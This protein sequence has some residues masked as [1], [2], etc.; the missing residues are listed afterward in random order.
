MISKF[1]PPKP[2]APEWYFNGVQT[3][4]SLILHIAIALSVKNCKILAP[5]PTGM[6]FQLGP[7]TGIA[8]FANCYCLISSKLQNSG[9]KSQLK[10][11]FNGVQTLA[12]LI[13]HLAIAIWVQ[14]CKIPPTRAPW[15]DISMRSK[16]WHF[17]FY[18]F[19]SSN[20]QNSG[21]HRR[22]EWYFN[23][24]LTLQILQIPKA[25]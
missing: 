11:Y 19:V 22:L 2:T 17:Q 5:K 9:P 14:N 3:L 24:V 6:I 4:A 20:L 7:S 18:G 21:H 1:R 23:G 12:L 25:L 10:W 13:L 8:N 16:H 15:N